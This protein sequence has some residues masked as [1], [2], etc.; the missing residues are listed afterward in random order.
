MFWKSVRIGLKRIVHYDAGHLPVA[1]GCILCLGL[2]HRPA[3]T[4]YYL[5]IVSA[6]IGAFYFAYTE[7]AH[8]G[9]IQM[10]AL[11]IYV[12]ESIRAHV[13]ELSGIRKAAYA[14]AVKYYYS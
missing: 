8:I 13:A 5:S 4:A 12:A 14:G 2:F 1:A 3:I 11:F 9:Y 6:Q 7:R 10:A